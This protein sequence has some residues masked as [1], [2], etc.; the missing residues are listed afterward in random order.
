MLDAWEHNR[1]FLHLLGLPPVRELIL[2]FHISMELLKE[3]TLHH[4]HSCQTKPFRNL[5]SDTVDGYRSDVTYGYE[6]FN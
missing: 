6:D 1:A 3:F 5:F 2:I 4:L